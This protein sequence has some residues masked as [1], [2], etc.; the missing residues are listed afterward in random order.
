MLTAVFS[1][2]SNVYAQ[3]G[4]QAE[5][6]KENSYSI[7][8]ET[9]ACGDSVVLRW[10]VDDPAVWMMANRDG[11]RIIRT[12]GKNRTARDERVVKPWELSKIS[13][14]FGYSDMKAGALAQALYGESTVSKSLA[15]KPAT[16]V[17]YV[18]RLREEQHSRQTIVYMLACRST[19]YADAAGLRF[20]DREV[21]VDATYEY[22]I[23]YAGKS[24]VFTCREA[25]EIVKNNANAT[26]AAKPTVKEVLVKQADGEKMAVYWPV[27]DCVGYYVERASVSQTEKASDSKQSQKS[28][29]K[30]SGKTNANASSAKK[31]LDFEPLNS[32][33]VV[34]ADIVSTSDYAG[35]SVAR[36]NVLFFD[37]LR[38]GQ[39]VVY[40]VRGYDLFGR[41]SEWRQSDAI[42]MLEQHPLASPELVRL[43]A[44][45]SN[46]CTVEWRAPSDERYAAFVVSFSGRADGEWTKV[47][48]KLAADSRSF[49]D[50][51]A[52]KRGIG[53]YRLYA[54]DSLGRL[55][56]SN[57]LPNIQTDSVAL[58]A[59]QALRGHS[60]LLKK[61]E[62]SVQKS[63]AIV[64][65]KWNEPKK[66]PSD[67]LGFRVFFAEKRDG[68]FVEVT[69]SL[70]PQYTYSDTINV[71]GI[72]SSAYYYV[73]AVDS[74]Y[75]QSAS[76]DTIE[77]DLPDV[78][79]P[80]PCEWMSTIPSSAKT[81]IKW[82]RSP[83]DDV[84]KYNVY[85]LSSNSSGW[86][87]VASIDSSSYGKS[88]LVTY[89]V[90]NE[91]LVF[92]V[93]YS[94]E[95]VDASGNTSGRSGIVSLPANAK[96]DAGITI[97]AKYNR[98]AAAV[99]LDW[100]YAA[101]PDGK[102]VG[103]IYRSD[104]GASPVAVGAFNPTQTTFTDSRLPKAKN[105]SY[106]IVLKMSQTA[107]SKPSESVRV[108]L[109]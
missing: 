29:S 12:G 107:M 105:V 10:M 56:Y 19:Q 61:D 44:S 9:L 30:G 22:T 68:R 53:Y 58:A 43:A 40:R 70:V 81:A 73:T 99:T 98:K 72:T 67:L 26:Q 34:K 15:A 33:P 39:T 48:G 50:S 54:Y 23:S 65:L 18:C 108:S 52:V 71:T 104:D 20:V 77:V 1:G 42:T 4:Q 95:A 32:I 93:Q 84:V 16:M 55:A 60:T 64:S 11:W 100:K 37:S 96:A 41:M 88:P 3:S 45:D 106:H 27:S 83:S 74:R 89:Q 90:N 75:N 101:K 38:P 13:S 14:T 86:Q 80:A 49:T 103:I 24:E 92:P 25:S 79:S 102:Y 8:L 82:Y 36:D 78:V 63:L 7:T 62:N 17:E 76:S 47:S 31:D 5:S 66:R 35:L 59:P 69:S 87:W 91:G 94:I 21:E 46:G 57:I 51:N 2:I 28:G 109:N 6:N 85:S 97:K